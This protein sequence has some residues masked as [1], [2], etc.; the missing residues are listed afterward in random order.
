MENTQMKNHQKSL[1]GWGLWLLAFGIFSA[2]FPRDVSFDV[3]HYQI[4]NGWAALNGRHSIDL[5][6]A[7]MHSF[8]NPA[9]QVFV[10]ILIDHFPGRIVAF[11]LGL[12]QGLILPA[13][14][15]FTDRL[16]RATGARISTGIILA[17]AATG[18]LAEVQFGL[19]ASTRNDA[20][21][22][23]AF[24]IAL[25]YL[26]P[27]YGGTPSYRALACASFIVGMGM[28]MKLTNAVY[29]SGFACAVLI[30]MP[31][32]REKLQAV[33]ICAG[34]GLAGIILLGGPWAWHLWQEFSN[35][36]FPM[37]NDLFH[38][39]LGPDASFRDTRY[40]P[41]SFWKSIIWPFY[42]LFEGTLINEE[43]FFDPRFQMTYIAA[44]VLPVTYLVSRGK[45]VSRPVLAISTAFL[46]CTLAWIFM[47]SIERYMAAAW[48]V[49]PSFLACLIC[50]FFPRYLTH[51]KALVPT[52]AVCTIIGTLYT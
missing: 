52:I 47:F 35:P 48:M 7:E 10:W 28:G 31:T 2:I 41:P 51:D 24:I 23:L 12:L 34:A 49:G 40:L 5:A 17:I 13:L 4:Y 19:F 42:F 30:I 20:V 43:G 25:I 1:L 39:P 21:S 46:V 11:I 33:M 26:L 44:F 15:I 14:F 22:A 9:W 6:A 45:K 3:A 37:A 32:W 36:V 38:A 8:L 50:V 18:F 27:K 29:V 16:L